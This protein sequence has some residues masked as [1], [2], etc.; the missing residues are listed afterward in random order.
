[1]EAERQALGLQGVLFSYYRCSACGG[2]DIFVYVH[3]LS[4]ESDD[5]FRLRKAALEAA[6][7]EVHGGEVEAVL[8]E[9]G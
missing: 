3:P 8:V 9:K 2:A 7:N 5:A 4:G 1:M 6:V